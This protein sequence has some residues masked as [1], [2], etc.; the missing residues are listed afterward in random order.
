M[1][2]PIVYDSKLYLNKVIL[3]LTIISTLSTTGIVV[4][5]ILSVIKI[6]EIFK[7]KVKHNKYLN[8]FFIKVE[9]A[10]FPFQLFLGKISNKEKKYGK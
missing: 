10:I 3:Y 7:L 5:V 8:N 6:L 2:N 9:M 1:K 4:A